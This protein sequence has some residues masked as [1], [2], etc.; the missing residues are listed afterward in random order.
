MRVGGRAR[1]ECADGEVWSAQVSYVSGELVG[2]KSSTTVPVRVA[3]GDI[4][5]VVV[6]TGE[7][8]VAAEARVLAASGSFMRLSR[9][10][11]TEGLERRRACASPCT[12]R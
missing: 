10:E 12:R 6:G 4:V 2:L 5:T 7:S 11:S 9:R 3:A 8:M 1:V